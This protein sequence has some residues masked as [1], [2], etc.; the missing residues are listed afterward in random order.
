MLLL[1]D[2]TLRQLDYV[3]AAGEEGSVTAAA[4]R[5]HRS[6]SALSMA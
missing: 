6:Q 4:Q 2:A 1:S 3:I 5:L